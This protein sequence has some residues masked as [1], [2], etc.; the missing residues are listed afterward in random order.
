MK[1]YQNAHLKQEAQQ[2][3]IVLIFCFSIALVMLLIIIFRTINTHAAPA[4]VMTKYYT[5]IRV[6]SG[7]TLWSIASDYITDEYKDMNE[8]IHEIC[9]INHIFKDEIYA[10]EYLIIPYYAPGD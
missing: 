3:H 1:N 9:S 10:G 5:S 7:D 8:Y 2:K 6:E 4:E